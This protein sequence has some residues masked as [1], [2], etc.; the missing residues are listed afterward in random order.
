MIDAT[1]FLILAVI[2]GGFMAWG[3]GAN[4]VANAMGTSVGAKAL[5]LKQ[6]IVV[7]AIF[8]VAGC[9]FAGGEVTQTIS[10]EIINPALFIHHPAL[11]VYGM[12]ASLLAAGCW[13]L[14]AT[15]RGWPVST[16]HSI[17]GAI[18][19]FALID[20]G[21]DAVNWHEVIKITSS[22]VLSP[23][24][25]GIIAFAIFMSIQRFI[26]NTP[27][28]FKSAQKIAPVYIFLVA[29]VVSMVTINKGL[30]HAHLPIG[31]W[32]GILLSIMFS[33]F[34]AGIGALLL[35]R[36][37]P[38]RKA[39]GVSQ[40]A[41]VEK[42][43]AVLMIFSACSMAFA[44]GSN[45]VA[46]A[47]GPLAAVVS[48]VQSGGKIMMNTGVPLWIIF[49]CAGGLVIGLATY[50]YKVT[51]TIGQH[52]TE[53]TPSRGFSAEVAAASTIIISSGTGLPVSTTQL[54]VGAV[55]GVGFARGIG[56]LNLTVIRNI[57]MSWVVTLP[58]GAIL[59]AVF[60]LLLKGI[61]GG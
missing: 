56:A 32:G 36:L 42:V 34:I 40:F 33:L 61:F 30:A 35:R 5:T 55:L 23:I 48:I 1:P 13:L 54:L 29:F 4:D 37:K 59:A 41:D 16:T 6:A 18:I 20:V 46:N 38:Q 45:D 49:L 60:F 22:W 31:F 28:P 53:L 21:P 9:L 57:F 24:I 27:S 26:F 15:N 17:V 51:A 43:F 44:H 14:I 25:A 39:K 58:A 10:H 47:I 50:G 19:G 2:F 12:L 3:I 11:L 7:A 52:I 8:E